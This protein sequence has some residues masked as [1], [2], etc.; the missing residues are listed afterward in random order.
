M[1]QCG[2]G[3]EA[4]ENQA[5]LV[6]ARFG[7][8]ATMAKYYEFRLLPD[9]GLG[10]AVVRVACGRGPVAVTG[11]ARRRRVAASSR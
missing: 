11:P 4:V 8:E 5:T 2:H 6:R 10:R 1:L 7:L 3:Q 9:F